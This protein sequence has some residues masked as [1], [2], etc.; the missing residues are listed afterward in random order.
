VK[1][2]A[3]PSSA[4]PFVDVEKGFDGSLHALLIDFQPV[5][6]VQIPAGALSSRNR[7]LPSE[8]LVSRHAAHLTLGQCVC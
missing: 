7:L 4:T 5:V 6:G 2:S 1:Y 8:S 3:K